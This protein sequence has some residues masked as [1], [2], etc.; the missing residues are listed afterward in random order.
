M[1]LDLLGLMQQQTRGMQPIQV[2]SWQIPAVQQQ[3]L[4]TNHKLGHISVISYFR[5]S[6]DIIIDYTGY[7]LTISRHTLWGPPVVSWFTYPM[8]I[9]KSALHHSGVIFTNLAIT[10]SISIP[11]WPP[12]ITMFH[13]FPRVFVIFQWS[14]YH[15]VFFWANVAR[16]ATGFPNFRR[17]P[18]QV[19]RDY[20]GDPG[21]GT[22]LRKNHPGVSEN[23]PQNMVV[24]GVGIDVPFLISF[25]L[26]LGLTSPSNKP[27]LL[28]MKYSLF[29]W[30]M[31]NI[32]T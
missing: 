23:G 10:H 4:D 20:A 24:S 5:T 13:H 2:C 22:K 30:V 16:G 11:G 28:E 8:S 29:S 18:D 32:R 1:Y 31:W 21:W 19:Q 26:D 12:W 9:V 6:I 3:Q 7:I 15:L 14:L 17:H 25:F 27:Y